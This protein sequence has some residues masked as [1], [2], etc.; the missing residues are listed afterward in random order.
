MK[1]LLE[2]YSYGNNLSELK[3]LSNILDNDGIIAIP[4]DSG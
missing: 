2:L 4:T 3:E 1:S